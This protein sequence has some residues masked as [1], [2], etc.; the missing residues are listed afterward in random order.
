M[1]YENYKKDKYFD[2][3]DVVNHLIRQVKLEFKNNIKLLDFLFIDEVQDLTINQIYLLSLIAKNV[4][5]YG[6]DTC[7]T[8]SKINRFRFS[9]LKTIFYG[10]SKIIK[11]YK[12]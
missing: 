10:F 7:Q 12:N 6:G 1:E 8:I 2:M 3:Q 9:D 4:E 11:G 5:M